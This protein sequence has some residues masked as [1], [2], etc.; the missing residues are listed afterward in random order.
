[1]DFVSELS[2][3]GS[4]TSFQCLKYFWK[5]EAFAALI[6]V[7][8]SKYPNSSPQQLKKKK[9]V[10]IYAVPVPSDFL[11][12]SRHNP[13]L[14]AAKEKLSSDLGLDLVKIINV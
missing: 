13:E 11:A 4:L 5:Q 1:M 14:A 2:T 10:E 9:D 6:Y 3:T 12:H 7:F 8:R